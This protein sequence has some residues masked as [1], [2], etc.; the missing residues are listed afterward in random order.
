MADD[1]TLRGAADRSRVNMQEDYEV[2]IG[3]GSG[4]LPGN[5]SP[6][7]CARVGVMGADVARKHGKPAS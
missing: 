3:P 1:R 5:N 7:P 6:T 4:T 2:R